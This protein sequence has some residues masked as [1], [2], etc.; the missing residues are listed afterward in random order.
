MADDAIKF[1]EDGAQKVQRKAEEVVG[2]VKGKVQDA[3]ARVKS[4]L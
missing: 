1:A 2:D 3:T 4:E